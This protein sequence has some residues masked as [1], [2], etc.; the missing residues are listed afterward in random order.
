MALDRMEMAR[1]LAGAIRCRT[2]SHEVERENDW[3]E[4]ERLHLFLREE[5]PLCHRVMEQEKVLGHSLLFRWPGRRPG[6]EGV[7]FLAHQDVVEAQGKWEHPPF[8]GI[9]EGGY[10]WGRGALDMKSQLIALFE[11]AEIL[12]RRGFIPA[13]DIYFAFSHDEELANDQGALETARLLESRGVRLRFALDEGTCCF[14]EGAPYGVAGTIATVGVCEKGYGV[15]TV[16]ASGEGGHASTPPA[17]T[18]LGKVAGAAARI[19]ARGA[20]PRLTGPARAFFEALLPHMDR[21]HAAL[22]SDM[23]GREGEICARLAGDRRTN[24]LTRSTLALT[25]AGGSPAH[26]ILPVTAWARFNARIA[27]WDDPKELLSRASESA[28]EEVTVEWESLNPPTPVSPVDEEY[29]ILEGAVKRAFPGMVCAPTMLLVATDSHHYY[30]ICRHIY[31]FSPFR[32][33]Q[34]DSHTIHAPNE[35][36]EIDSL[37]KGGEFFLDLMERLAGE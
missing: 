22:F 15:L 4:F 28:G 25:M 34:A 33:Y 19:E 20:A 37:L 26:N 13:R 1:R 35:R 21:E 16:R 18:A 12:C 27:P 32:S 8:D 10:V 11:A 36:I 23:E 29:R 17:S 6:G 24:A 31:R 7:L 5:Y 30:P 3:G 9:I 2:V 14:L